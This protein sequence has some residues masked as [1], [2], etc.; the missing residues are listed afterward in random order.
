MSSKLESSSPPGW[1]RAG[2]CR[3]SQGWSVW[4]ARIIVMSLAATVGKAAQIEALSFSP[5]FTALNSQGERQVGK[6][7]RSS[8]STSVQKNFARLTPDRQSKKGALWATRSIGTSEISVALKFRI[9]GQG[10]KYFG[11][12]MALWLTDS[13]SYRMGDFHGSTEKFK[14]IGVI[15]DTFKNAEMSSY[16]K[17]ITVVIN[18]GSSDQEQMLTSSIGCNGDIRYHEDRGDFSVSSASRIKFVVEPVPTTEGADASGGTLVLSVFLDANNSGEYRDCVASTT[19]PKALDP[20][21]LS[22]TYIGI[23]ASTGQL[24]DNH[25]VL[26]LDVFSD[27]EIHNEVESEIGSVPYFPAGEGVSEERFENIE[28]TLDSLLAKIDY[29]EHHLEHEL[30]AVDDH[31]RTTV[32]KLAKQ[33]QAAEGRIELLEQKV[34]SSVEDSLTQRISSLEGAM[35]DAVHKRVKAVEQNT[36][37]RVQETVGEQLKGKGSGWTLGFLFL[38]AVDIVAAIAVYRW[39]IK[40]KKSHLL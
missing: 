24:A 1:G 7:W 8:G 21:W 4:V 32:D 20:A 28:T 13:R 33:E 19:L 30:V 11:D 18:E 22:R 37:D 12:G 3:R 14:G 39:Y 31:V 40:F 17:D 9:S 6:S 34:T 36:L 25:D 26:S 38:V 10:K 29:L 15:I 2:R 35:R 27:K 5:P 16:H 23:T